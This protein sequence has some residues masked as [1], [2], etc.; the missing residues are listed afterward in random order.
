MMAII[1]GTRTI[2]VGTDT[3]SYISL[4]KLTIAHGFVTMVEPGYGFAEYVFCKLGFGFNLFQTMMCLIMGY[5][6]YSTIRKASVD[7]AFSLFVFYGMYFM[8]YSMNIY[9]QIFAVIILFFGYYYLSKE[10]KIKFSIF[11]I[12]AML[13]H[14]SSVVAFGA[15]FINKL[16]ISKRSRTI[17]FVFL[18]LMIGFALSPQVFASVSG[19]Y[20]HYILDSNDLIRTGTRLYQGIVLSIFWSLLF[21]FCLF[22]TDPRIR[23]NFWFKMFYLATILNNVFLRL[24]LGLRV[25]LIVSICQ[26]IALPLCVKYRKGLSRSAITGVIVLFLSI[27]FFTMLLTNSA[28]VV[29]YKSV[30]F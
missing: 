8:M 24:E 23:E 2:E 3:K 26:V 19:G 27:F 12:I 4:Y 22:Y 21:I 14:M 15:L 13:F 1:I 9:R 11:V 30:L 29:P 20:A 7:Y 18:S 16:K 17:L 10:Q 6:L 28:D 5:L 25:L